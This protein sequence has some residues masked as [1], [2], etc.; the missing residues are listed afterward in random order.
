MLSFLFSKKK[1]IYIIKKTSFLNET[2]SGN[3]FFV[4]SIKATEGMSQN[5]SDLGKTLFLKPIVII[6]IPLAFID[7]L[8]KHFFIYL[9]FS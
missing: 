5:V 2:H 8:N 1:Y 6:S 3:L 4:M 9:F 7:V